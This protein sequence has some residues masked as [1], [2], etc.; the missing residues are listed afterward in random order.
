MFREMRRHSQELSKEECIEILINQ[1]RGVLAVLGDDEYPYAVPMDYVYVD[2]RLYFHSAKEGH[3]LDSI[4]RHSKAS[5]CVMNE[6]VK[7]EDS[8]WY[9]FKSVIAFGRIRIL[10]DSNEKIDKLTYLGNKYFP[11]PEDTENEI[12]RLLDRTE[13]FELNVEHMSGKLVREK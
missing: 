11:T 4:K 9:T 12:V 1:P 13:V 7:K 6:G 2:G 3:K 10:T 5:F 8:W